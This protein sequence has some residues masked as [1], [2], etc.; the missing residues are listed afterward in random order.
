MLR[1]R[2][3]A[4]YERAYPL[5]CLSD[6]PIRC[7]TVL[8]QSQA[9]VRFDCGDPGAGRTA[10]LWTLY[11]ST[12]S[13]WLGL[14]VQPGLRHQSICS[15]A[16]GA[17]GHRPPLRQPETGAM[18]SDDYGLVASCGDSARLWWKFNRYGIM[19]TEVL[20]VPTKRRC[21][22][23]P[24]ITSKIQA[25]HRPALENRYV[26]QAGPP[27]RS[28]AFPRWC[29]CTSHACEQADPASHSINR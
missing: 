7:A 24:M 9:S 28:F 22:E 19:V 3:Y 8:N 10:D 1:A 4:G 29:R 20:H 26:R 14:G 5:R 13:E 25:R 16:A 27:A 15:H 11:P 6:D 12:G 18:A 23:R 2:Q 21:S 17:S